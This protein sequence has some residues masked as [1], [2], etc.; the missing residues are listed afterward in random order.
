MTSFLW[1]MADDVPRDAHVRAKCVEVTF[2][3]ETESE[4][5]ISEFIGGGIR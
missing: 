3:L 2:G 5:P 4:D 1:S